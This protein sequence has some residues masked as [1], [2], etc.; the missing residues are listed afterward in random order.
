MNRTKQFLENIFPPNFKM[1]RFKKNIIKVIVIL[2]FGV[3]PAIFC[4]FFVPQPTDRYIHITSFRYGKNPSVIRCYRGDKLHLTFSTNDTGHSFFLEEFDIDVK[5]NPASEE[6]AVFKTSD[7]TG[8][9]LF[10]RELILTAKHPGILNY[11]ISKSNYRCHVWCGPL[12]AFEQGKLIILPNTLFIFSI[13]CIAGILILWFIGIFRNKVPAGKSVEMKSDMKD[14]LNNSNLLRRIII[15]RW[16]QV[17]ITIFAMLMIYIVILT[18]VFGTKVSGRNLGVLMMWAIWLFLLVAILTPIG[19][20]IWCTICPLPFFGDMFQRKSIF[21]PEKG[22]TKDYNNKF[23]GFFLKWPLWLSN[24]WLRLIV[25]LILATFSTTLVAVPRISGIVVLMLLL[26]PTCM[27]LVWEL[28]AFCRYV[29]PV[30]VFVSPFSRMSLLA[31][32]NKSDL[33]CNQCKPHYCEKGSNDGWA[34]PYGINVGEMKENTDC[35]LC[36]ECTRSCLY[37]NVSLYIR[38]FSSETGTRNLSEAWLTITVFTIAIVY[39]V[40]Y[41]G[42]WP[43]ARDYVN[44]VDKQNWDLFGIY[45]ISLWFLSLMIMPGIIFLFSYTGVRLS[46]INIAVKKVF[47][48]SAGALLPLGLTLWI[49]FVIPMLF[50]NITFISQSISDPFGWGW[51]FFGTA[52]IPWHQFLPQFIPWGQAIFVLTGLFLSLRNLKNSWVNFQGNSNQVLWM[53]LPVAIFITGIAIS[54]LVFFTN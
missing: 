14:L 8:K 15:S 33:I 22:K 43:M 50:V 46:K 47:Q 20:R 44:I 24:S 27:S 10:T 17:V 53:V 25:F 36:L 41:L 38:P 26:V 49:A 54:M 4:Q 6:V 45:T 13:G 42:P 3:L 29:C 35:G 5:V 1:D 48:K 31:L 9:P 16:P 2:S 34:C 51:D 18:S 37:N 11:I 7:P 40:L 12:H 30:S 52:N 28:R 19:G 23:S 39:S 21:S 32:R